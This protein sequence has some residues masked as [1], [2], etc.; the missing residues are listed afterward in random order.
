[1][2]CGLFVVGL[3]MMIA[4]ISILIVFITIFILDDFLKRDL[5]FLITS[6][7]EKG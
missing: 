6:P 2:L 7:I 1:M 5:Y 3:G 4:K